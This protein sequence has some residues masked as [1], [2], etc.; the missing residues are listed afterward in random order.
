MQIEKTII[1]CESIY[2]E[3]KEH[4]ILLKREWDKTKESAMVIMI[5]PSE[6][7]NVQT[8]LTTMCVINNL[9]KLNVGSVDI[10]NMYTRITN[11]ISFRFQ[12]DEELL[13]NENDEY[14]KKSAD[15]VDYIILAWGQI[16]Q[17]TKRVRE[18][19]QEILVALAP[20]AEKI[21]IIKDE[22][23]RRG[24]H[25]LTPQIRN[26]WILEK[27]TMEKLQKLM[28]PPEPV[29]KHN[30]QNASDLPID[31]EVENLQVSENHP[32][33]NKCDEND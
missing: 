20:Y 22:H 6:I 5:N 9:D 26:K 29:E 2:S 4:R 1:K 28:N 16:G 15:K 13:V 14:M 23:G 11:K 31:K 3:D 21:R 27:I 30:P 18:R 8:D 33:I 25:P 24:L 7:Q 32:E 10:F 12:D 19:Q 17:H